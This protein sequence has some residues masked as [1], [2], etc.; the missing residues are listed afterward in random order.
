MELITIIGIN[1]RGDWVFLSNLSHS[2]PICLCMQ[3]QVESVDQ[4]E[5]GEYE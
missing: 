4:H 5:N 3:M 1:I 2:F